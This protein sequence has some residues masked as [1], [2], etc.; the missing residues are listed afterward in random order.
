VSAQPSLRFDPEQRFTCQQ[1]ARCCRRGW[2][3][4]VSAAEAEAYGRAQAARWFREDDDAPEGA[5]ADPFVP[6]AGGLLSIRK[7]A[8]GACGFLSRDN[9]CRIHEEL[10]GDRKPLAC[11]LFPFRIHPGEGV[12]LVSASFSCPTVVKNV[13][14]PLPEQERAL[15]ALR[16]EWQRVF[17]E[18]PGRLEWMAD[19]PLGGSTLGTIREVL[20][21]LLDRPGPRGAPDLPA[22]LQRVAARLD[23]WTRWRVVKLSPEEFAEYVELTGRYAVQS[24]KPEG[25]RPAPGRMARLLRRGFLLLVLAGREPPRS[26]GALGRRWRLTR[27]ALHLHGLG[28]AVKGVDLRAARRLR[29]DLGAPDVAPLVRHYLHA[30]FTNMG[31]GRRPVADEIGVG[32]AILDAALTLAA[33]HAARQGRAGVDAEALC[34]GLVEAAD[35]AH[36]P[37]RSVAGRAMVLLAG[38][39]GAALDLLPR[40]PAGISPSAAH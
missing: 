24:D 27:L 18:P 32:V 17:P 3:I 21:A 23:D 9:R 5:S 13:G 38:G 26:A 1:C 15:R 7:R 31:A 10:G 34:A 11:R 14:T 8:D 37:E 40:A 25:P 2:D 4:V 28:P 19:R 20:L 36:T 35:L 29:V 16:H 12:P 33:L 39:A 30:V 22:N 6:A